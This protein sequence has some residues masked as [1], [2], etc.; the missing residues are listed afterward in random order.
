M[1]RA[2]QGDRQ[3]D[4]HMS[5]THASVLPCGQASPDL[6]QRS[7]GKRNHSPVSI[8]SIIVWCLSRTIICVTQLTEINPDGGLISRTCV[9]QHGKKVLF[10]N[11][12]F[13]E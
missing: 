8:R 4:F 5:H 13:E 12:V 11:F 9:V 6:M 3:V 2:R 7:C 1:P 10:S